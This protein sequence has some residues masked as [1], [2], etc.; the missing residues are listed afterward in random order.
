MVSSGKNLAFCCE[1]GQMQGMLHGVHGYGGACDI[2]IVQFCP[3]FTLN[4]LQRFGTQISSQNYCSVWDVARCLP[5]GSKVTPLLIPDPICPFGLVLDVSNH[6]SNLGKHPCA[7][8]K[9]VP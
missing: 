3:N 2:R 4:L 9:K 8:H 1:T 6:D 5:Y 7:V